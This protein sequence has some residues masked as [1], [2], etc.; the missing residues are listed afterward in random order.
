ML[1]SIGKDSSVMLHLARKSF[2]PGNLPFPLLYIDTGWKFKEMYSFR[3]YISKSFNIELIV[4]SNLKGKLL[5][6]N[7]F[8]NSSSKYTDIMKTEA[9]KEAINKYKFDV[10]FAGARRDEEKSRSKERIYSFRHSFHQW[11]PKKQ[12]PELWW[13]YNGQINKGES[14]RVFFPSL[15]RLN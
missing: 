13:N 5:G 1:Y 6:V 9:L 12:R 2:Y 14:I 7:P 4:H 10:A 15:I 3:D 11:D 8:Q